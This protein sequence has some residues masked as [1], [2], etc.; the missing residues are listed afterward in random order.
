MYNDPGF[1]TVLM[2]C[3]GTC[4]L[5]NDISQ[6]ISIL[7]DLCDCFCQLHFETVCKSMMSVYFIGSFQKTSIPPPRRKLEVNPPTPFGCSNTFTI[8]RNN[9][10]SPSPS[11][12]QKF[13]PWG[14]CGSFLERPIGKCAA[15][16]QLSLGDLLNFV[17]A[18]V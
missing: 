12:Q 5:L 6:S 2:L 14:E 9:F 17:L 4:N 18:S 7:K 1:G 15:I 11:G 10:V 3:L 16:T 8:M 13:P